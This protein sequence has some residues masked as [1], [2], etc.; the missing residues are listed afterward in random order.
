[1]LVVPHYVSSRAISTSLH[2]VR[3]TLHTGG[4][5]GTEKRHR[6]T[7][8]GLCA[9]EVYIISAGSESSLNTGV[10]ARPRLG[11]IDMP[12]SPGLV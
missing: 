11:E 10:G 2:A 3:Q 5:L 12:S 6:G 9:G 4:Y 7:R 8:E 1:M